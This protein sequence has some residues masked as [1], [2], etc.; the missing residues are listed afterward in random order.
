M[1]FDLDRDGIH[2]AFVTIKPEMLLVLGDVS[3][4]GVE[5]TESPF[6]GFPCHVILG[7]RD[8][9]ECS[10]LN[11]NN[12]SWLACKF[13]GLDSTGCSSFEIS[14]IISV[15]LNAVALLCGNNDLRFGVER[16]IEWESVTAS[17]DESASFVERLHEVA[18]RKI[19]VSYRSAPVLGPYD[20]K[21]TIPANASD[22]IFQ[23]LRPRIVFSA[24]SHDFC[25]RLHLDGTR[26]VTVPVMTWAAKEDPGF[27]IAIF[28]RNGMIS[29][30]GYTF[31]RESYVLGWPIATNNNTGCLPTISPS[32]LTRMVSEYFIFSQASEP[33]SET[34]IKRSE[35]KFLV[36]SLT[37]VWLRCKL[38]GIVGVAE[39][40]AIL[41]DCFTFVKPVAIFTWIMIA[42]YD[43]RKSSSSGFSWIASPQ[44]ASNVVIV[45]GKS[46]IN[47]TSTEKHQH[48]WLPGSF[49]DTGDERL[50]LSRKHQIITIVEDNS[51]SCSL[52]SQALVIFRADLI[53]TDLPIG[54]SGGVTIEESQPHSHREEVV[55]GSVY[56]SHPYLSLLNC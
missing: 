40:I 45:F 54:Q 1:G 23:D 2:K 26:E 30:T 35:S 49:G 8:V 48:N 14:N 5:L 36:A 6:L 56:L 55:E 7:D 41:E 53:W 43:L 24:L 19:P 34:K 46:H 13:P 28:K 9:G 12:I 27:V 18:W 25:D 47:W 17:V 11:A 39:T 15:S 20:L 50:L 16:V 33:S 31:A 10:G 21:Q 38:I 22:Y 42:K 44:D 29:V 52:E 32:F 4:K 3:A 51:I 37:A